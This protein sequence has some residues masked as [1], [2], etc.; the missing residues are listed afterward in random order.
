M[1]RRTKTP[2]ERRVLRNAIKTSDTRSSD[3]ASNVTEQISLDSQLSLPQLTSPNFSL[4]AVGAGEPWQNSAMD[5][6]DF[7][8]IP[9]PAVYDGWSFSVPVEKQSR[10][11]PSGE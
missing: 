7:G 4:Q 3:L 1:L 10:L 8:T 5:S 2:S 11:D 6:L 9:E